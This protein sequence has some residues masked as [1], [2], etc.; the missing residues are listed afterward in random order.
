MRAWAEAALKA[1]AAGTSMPWVTVLKP[2]DPADVERVI[3]STRYLDLDLTHKT[4]EV[5]HTW[6]HPDFHG[7]GANAEAK[8]LQL[9]YAFET[10]GLNRVALKTHHENL[11]SQAAMRKLGAVYEGTFRNHYLM[12]DGS[13]RHSVWCSITREEWPGVKATL[14]RRTFPGAAQ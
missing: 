10:L 7:S 1:E 3:G 14:E 6:L 5:G 12:P 11:H 2:A 8:L 13:M 9:Q 4:V